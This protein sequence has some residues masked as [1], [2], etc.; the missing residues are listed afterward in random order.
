MLDR[1]STA[2]LALLAAI[3]SLPVSCSG[4]QSKAIAS[5]APQATPS[6]VSPS[7]GP[8][9]YLAISGRK[10][11]YKGQ[12]VVL[13]G[14]NFNNEY[15]LA[16]CNDATSADIGKIA[17]NEADYAKVHSWGGNHVRWG[18]SYAWYAS[19]RAQFFAVM[20]QHVAWARQ[21]HLWM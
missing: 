21:Q 8:S 17:Y 13:R 6:P 16:C 7:T 5:P 4:S 2:M 9:P 11:S 14:I 15:A 20:D 18:M 19:D 10:F 1:S 3:A 12:E